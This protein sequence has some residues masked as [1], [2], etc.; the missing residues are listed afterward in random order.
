MRVLGELAASA[1]KS[2]TELVDFFGPGAVNALLSV[3]GSESRVPTL[4]GAL[5]PAGIEG[6]FMEPGRA[7]EAVQAGGALI[8]AAAGI[9][10][11]ARQ[12]GT[13]GSSILDLLGAG[14][15]AIARPVAQGGR[16]A[17]QVA[18]EFLPSLPPSKAA[19]AA[20]LPL[21]RATGD[22][23]TFGYRL[24]QLGQV[25]DDPAQ[26]AAAK[27]GLPEGL[28][29]MVRDSPPKARAKM[30]AMVDIVDSGR[31][32]FRTQAMSRPLDI[33]GDSIASRVKVVKA[34]NEFAG[35]RLDSVAKGLKGQ[36]VDVSP[37]IDGMM[38][39]LD[40][41]GIKFN[42]A[43]GSLSFSGSDLEGLPGTQRV[44]KNM[45]NRLRDTQ[46]PDA[47]DVHRMKRFID[48]QVSYGKSQRGLGGKTERVLK[49]LRHDLDG[50]L[51][52]KFP[53]YNRVNTD[54]SETIRVLDGL[55]DVAG[56]KMDLTG[57][58]A[59]KALG[60][61]SRRLLSNAQ[62][63]VPLM[64]SIAELD[65]VARRYVT[66]QGQELVPY[67][68]VAQRARVTL[69]DLDDD[70]MGQVMFVDELE[71]IF[72]TAARTSL[73]GDVSKAAIGAA[74]LALDGNTSIARKGLKWADKKLSGRDPEKAIKAFREL[75][76]E[77]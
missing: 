9:T 36:Q 23:S 26:K 30:R 29:T 37:A 24:N 56:Q 52:A 12:I 40:D 50:L 14:S 53:E 59:D 19:R 8:P 39:N 35:S 11:V 54:Y 31:K 76:Q 1:N 22:V 6:G 65:E 55:Q 27:Q 46:A 18:S 48:E 5:A 16:V 64:D 77:Q 25:V 63:R 3:S 45:L 33:A 34:A 71:K 73:Q 51:D 47:Y 61:L 28:I 62:S 68:R 32:N 43:D 57:P 70:I 75:L 10:P 44:I 2:V 66:P 15:S 21:K 42:P 38:S 41:M 4:T 60:T 17:A 49:G 20:E 7:R 69:A 13:V 67:R 74:D 72:G 58:N